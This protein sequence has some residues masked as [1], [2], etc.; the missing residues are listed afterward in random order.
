[1]SVGAIGSGSGVPGGP[2]A[3]APDAS[4]FASKIAAKMMNELDANKDGSIDKKEFVTGL[5]AKGVSAAD[6]G[7]MF[8]AVDTKKTGSVGQGDI[9]TAV[10]NG[11]LKPPPGA[12]PPEGGGKP[13]GGGGGGDGGSSTAYDAADTNRDGTVSSLEALVYS[14]KH[15]TDTK[16]QKTSPA[17]LGKNVNTTS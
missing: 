12:R 8:D 5:Q 10:K 3:G 17:S 11:T 7:K 4:K 9:E 15:P 6:A 13:A 16:H 14:M 2:G 1:M